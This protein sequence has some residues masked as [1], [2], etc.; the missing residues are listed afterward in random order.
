MIRIRPKVNQFVLVTDYNDG[1]NFVSIG[2]YLRPVECL[3]EKVHRQTDRQTDGRTDG[4]TDI[5]RS[6][7]EVILSRSVYILVGLS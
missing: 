1:P 6:T 4:R 2:L 7:Q 3:Q 5:A